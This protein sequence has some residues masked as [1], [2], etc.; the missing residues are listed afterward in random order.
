MKEVSAAFWHAAGLDGQPVV[1]LDDVSD[2]DDHIGVPPEVHGPL[3]DTQ[4]R[5]LRE[6]IG[7]LEAGMPAWT[8]SLT[9]D[10]RTTAGKKTR[11]W[12][13]DTIGPLDEPRDITRL[14]TWRT[15]RLD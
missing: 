13:T 15:Y 12:A 9:E 6:V 1:G 11:A 7:F 5:S 10:E 8:W 4:Q 3:D 2:L 14:I